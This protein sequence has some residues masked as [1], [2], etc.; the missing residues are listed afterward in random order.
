LHL[1]AALNHTKNYIT[2]RKTSF[3]VGGVSWLFVYF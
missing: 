2:I 1:H 3:S